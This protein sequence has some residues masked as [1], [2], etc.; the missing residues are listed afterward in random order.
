MSE[1]KTVSEREAVLRERAAWV[2][3]KMDGRCENAEARAHVGKACSFC[4]AQARSIYPL[5]KIVPRVVTD[6]DGDEWR[7]TQNLEVRS[8]GQRW[9]SADFPTQMMRDYPNFRVSFAKM[10]MEPTEEIPDEC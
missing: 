1:S 4:E 2:A 5:K 3:A 9:M 6:P 10:L 7:F 8:G